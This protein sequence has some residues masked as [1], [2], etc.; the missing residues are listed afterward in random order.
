M[1]KSGD[2]RNVSQL[3]KA[4]DSRTVEELSESYDRWAG[5]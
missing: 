3:H 1:T 5:E 4:Y 2:D